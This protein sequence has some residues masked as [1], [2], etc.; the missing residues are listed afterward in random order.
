MA[1]MLS[2]SGEATAQ[3]QSGLSSAVV[4]V[5]DHEVLELVQGVL[6]LVGLLAE[7]LE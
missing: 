5:L 4:L 1:D 3:F 7:P 6:S 2:L